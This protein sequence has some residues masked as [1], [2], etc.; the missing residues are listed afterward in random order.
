[1]RLPGPAVAASIGST[2]IVGARPGATART[3]AARFHARRA[4]P[5]GTGGYAV[6]TG[7]ARAFAGA[8]RA[9]GLLVYAQPNTRRAVFSVP[10]DPL[11]VSPDAWR[12]VVARPS[13]DP[14]VPTPA[15]PLIALL[16]TQLD[17]TH[18]EF[19]RSNVTTIERFKVKSLHGTA[20]A[21][22]AAAPVNGNGI[23]G[24]W[25]S[26]RAL[27]IPFPHAN[28]ITCDESANAIAEAIDRGAAVI[29][30]SYG[31]AGYCYPEYVA[32]QFAVAHGIVPV[33]AAGNE[34]DGTNP[35]EY[36]AS[37]PHVLTVAAVR[38]GGKPVGFSNANAAIDLAAP[39]VGIMAAV[40]IALDDEGADDGY[41]HLSGTSFSTPMVSAAVAWLRQARPQFTSGQVAQAIRLSARDT[42][43]KGWDPDTGFGVLSVG[44]A[45][46]MAHPPKDTAEPNDDIVW[47]DGRAFGAP[48]PLTYDGTGTA[49]RRGLLDVYEDPADVYRIRV[50][51]H[52][53]VLITARPTGRRDDVA[54]RVFRRKATRIASRSYRR[55]LRHGHRKERIALRNR[56]RWP[57]TYYVSVTVQ[58]AKLLD[59]TYALRV[60]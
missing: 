5:A 7:H 42:G 26:A 34:G 47:V 19:V 13:L 3:L 21:S 37:L 57:K 16:D 8:L 28:E 4:G 11:S 55:S 52:R 23:V 31:S 48:A 58:G 33:A 45:L 43:P 49:W 24:V 50:N 17:A 56:G 25:P 35:L 40:P 30:M 9:R 22:V 29:N 6:A 1:M 15:S 27:N 39:G 59:A 46:E 38:P 36:P 12:R 51:G 53:R 14:P 18:P 41:M 32:L 2:W 10:D 60:G 54:L 20:T 44:R